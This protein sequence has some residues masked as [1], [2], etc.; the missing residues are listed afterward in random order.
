MK[1]DAINFP[2]SVTICEVGPRDGL[3][4]EKRILS[5]EERVDLINRL[6][7]SGFKVIEVGSFMHPTAVPQMA[8]TDE[9]FKR[10]TKKS[11]VEYRALIANLKGVDR[12]FACGCKKV[13]LNVSASAAHNRANLNKTP[14][15]SMSEFP[16]CAEAARGKGLDISGSISMP[17]GSPWEYKIPIAD[18][19]TIVDSY[20]D[21]GIN[22]ISLSD[23]AGMAMPDHVFSV[24][25]E[26]KRHYPEVKWI[27]HF[28]NTRGMGIA[29]M[30][31]GMQAGIDWFDSSV[32]GIGGCPFIPGATGNVASED[33]LHMFHEM[34]IETRVDLGSVIEIARTVRILIG[35]DLPSFIL[36]AGR[37]SDLLP[38]S[39]G[40]A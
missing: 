11:G 6:S 36:K 28:H 14:R 8:D 16:T 7:D 24:C 5:I 12:A 26:M 35:H 9:V 40:M 21:V 38:L 33:I 37:N 39:G 3:Q 18:I 30:I 2:K 25:T 29:N 10:I 34:G 27:L 15:E 13:K 20:L 1:G 17:F 22:E 4:N 32:G 23:A 31:A 19:E